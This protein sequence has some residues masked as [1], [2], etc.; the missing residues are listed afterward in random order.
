MYRNM[1]DKM[2]VYCMGTG[3]DIVT[4]ERCEVCGGQ[5]QVDR[6]IRYDQMCRLCMG[7]GRD[8]ITMKKCEVCGGLGYG[9]AAPEIEPPVLCIHVTGGKPYGDRRTVEKL[10]GEVQG[11]V[12]ICETYLGSETLDLLG[13]LD[14]AS[15]VRVL[16]GKNTSVSAKLTREIRAF[17]KEHQPFEFRLHGQQDLHDRYIL[18]DRGITLLGHGLK[19]V[20]RKESFVVFFD[21]SIAEDM[22]SDVASA[23]DARWQSAVPI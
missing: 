1:Y 11:D 20:G 7:T 5:G 12:R 2:C 13:S 9:S 10:L 21:A 19:D 17:R 8:I 18:D 14:S 3:R 16:L 6:V 23:F 22:I 15:A 4:M